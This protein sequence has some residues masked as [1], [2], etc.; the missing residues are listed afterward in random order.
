MSL[1]HCSDLSLK[2]AYFGLLR[3]LLKEDGRSFS[4]KA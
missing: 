2:L 1:D 4:Q 3:L